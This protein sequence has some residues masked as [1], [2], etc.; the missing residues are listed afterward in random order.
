M[1]EPLSRDDRTRLRDIYLDDHWAGAAAGL[2]LAS[3]LAEE[4]ADSSWGVELALISNQINDDRQALADIRRLLHCDGGALKKALA[5]VGER[6][7]RLKPNGRITRYSP[8]SR[9]LE[10]EALI[11]GVAAKQRLWVALHEFDQGRGPLADF[12]FRELE[13]RAVSQLEL[14]GSVHETA[15]IDLFGG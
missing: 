9:V 14:L 1:T 8:L 12:D 15:V 5:L 6:L 2:A 3:R 13:A 11:S 7:S 4:N 10:L